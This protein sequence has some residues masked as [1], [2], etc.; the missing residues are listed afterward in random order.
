MPSGQAVPML[1]FISSSVACLAAISDKSSAQAAVGH[2]LAACLASIRVELIPAPSLAQ[3]A[4]QL[5]KASLQPALAPLLLSMAGKAQQPDIEKQ[6]PAAVRSTPTLQHT[7]LGD[8]KKPGMLSL[9]VQH[10]QQEAM[11]DVGS[12]EQLL[13]C[14]LRLYHGAVEVHGQCAGMQ[15]QVDPLPGQASGLPQQG[16][17]SQAAQQGAPPALLCVLCTILQPSQQFVSSARMA[18]LAAMLHQQLCAVVFLWCLWQFAPTTERSNMQGQQI[19]GI[20]RG[21][22]C[23]HAIHLHLT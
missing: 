17:A 11:L 20:Q 15:P 5:L 22:K 3:A 12:K 18:G 2:I 19:N 7:K 21:S 6:P 4:G 1:K 10:T 8:G 13:C 14:L 9:D 16:S 23:M